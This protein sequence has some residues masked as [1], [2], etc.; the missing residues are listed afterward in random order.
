MIVLGIDPGSV[1]TGYGVVEKKGAALVH[2]AHGILSPGQ[3]VPLH[4]RLLF[5]SSGLEKI[6]EEYR[7]EALSIESLF[8]AKNVNSTMVLSHARGVALLAAAKNALEV[9]EYAPMTV[10]QAV[11][12]YGKATKEQVQKM[13]T[14]LLKISPV[15]KSDAADALAIAVCHIHSAG[16]NLRKTI[17]G[18]APKGTLAQGR[19][20]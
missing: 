12:G 20:R 13:V 4:E 7:P 17:E 14:M 8:Y 6:M 3:D 19:G 9:F 16:P 18:T 15:M 1:V 10:K 2:I 11:T 5:I